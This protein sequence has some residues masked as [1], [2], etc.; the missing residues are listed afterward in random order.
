[1]SN[2][3]KKMTTNIRPIDGKVHIAFPEPVDWVRLSA[4]EARAFAKLLV[5][6]AD[7]LDKPAGSSH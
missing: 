3:T 7:V 6:C 1:M 2:E 4:A 5:D